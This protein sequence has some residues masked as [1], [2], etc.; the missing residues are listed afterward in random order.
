[1]FHFRLEKPI[2]FIICHIV[3][4]ENTLQ[5]VEMSAHHGITNR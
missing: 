4:K 5:E 2:Q 3:V 1:M